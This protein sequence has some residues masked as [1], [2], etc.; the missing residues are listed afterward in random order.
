M[1]RELKGAV[2]EWVEHPTTKRRA[3]IRLDKGSM[4]FFARED[5]KD[6]RSEPFQ[7][8]NGSEVR[9]WLYK[10]LAFTTEQDRLE[11]RPVIKIEHDSSRRFRYRDESQVYGETLA[12][13]IDRF[14]LALTKDER[15]WQKIEWEAC[16]PESQGFIA[17]NERYAESKRYA[18][19]PKSESIGSHNKPFRLPSFE[20]SGDGAKSVVPYTPELWEGLKLIVEKIAEQ[21]KLLKTMLSTRSGVKLVAEVGAGRIPLQLNPGPPPASA[22]VTEKLPETV[23]E[24]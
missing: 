19:G 11:W 4:T 7:S 20:P 22:P 18:Q 6:L 15:T 24:P 13:E 14:Y 2:V 12:V 17:E 10:Q 21:R 23:E 3:P 8:K 9:A 1:S 5:D 16:D